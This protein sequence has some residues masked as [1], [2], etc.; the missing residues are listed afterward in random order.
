MGNA[1]LRLKLMP[2]KLL[3]IREYLKVSQRVMAQLLE[4]P[5][6]GRVSEY[7]DGVHE[8]NLMVTLAYSRLGKVSMASVVDDEVN[9]NE[10]CEQLGKAELSIRRKIVNVSVA[11]SDETRRPL[12]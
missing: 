8:P 7:E 1:R 12:S 9:V 4:L 6:K 10:F 11:T 2:Q 5:K 3:L